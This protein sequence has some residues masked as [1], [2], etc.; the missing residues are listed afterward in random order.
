MRTALPAI[1]FVLLPALLGAQDRPWCASVE[2]TRRLT[3]QEDGRL[4]GPER[5]HGPRAGGDSVIHV[6]VVVH[7]V[8][9]TPA[10]NVPAPAIAAMLEQMN[11]DLNLGNPELASVRE[12]FTPVLGNAR[13]QL[14]LAHHDPGGAATTGIVRVQSPVIWFDPEGEPDAMKFA[15][16]GSAAWDPVRYLN[17]WICDISS[18]A[19]GNALRGYAYLPVDG[20]VGSAV[21]GVVLDPVLGVPTTTR[22]ATHELGHYLGLLH[23]W[24]DGGCGSDDGLADTPNTDTPTYSC[25]NP[26]LMKCGELTQ[27]ENFMEYSNCLAMFTSEQAGAMRAVLQGVRAE[28][29]D[30]TGCTGII[31]ATALERVHPSVRL[32]PNPASTTVQLSTGGNGPCTVHLLDPQ[33]RLLFSR[34]YPR[35]PVEI[36]LHGTLSGLHFVRVVQENSLYLLPLSILD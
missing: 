7:V 2:L 16:L 1:L 9:N 35:T 11:A 20:V 12:Q 30:P 23:P 27:Y 8:W 25:A 36:D 24:G 18:G 29:Q 33:G 19:G 5:T 6:Q 34:N 10:E 13:I 15:P 3:G 32:Y 21:D 31:S 26:L 14:C 22:T 4:R 28:L 17:I